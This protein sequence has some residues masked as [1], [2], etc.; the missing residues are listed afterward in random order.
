MPFFDPISVPPNQ[1][2]NTSPRRWL[3]WFAIPLATGFLWLAESGRRD[4]GLNDDGK[5]L[6]IW[7]GMLAG[8]ACIL[9]SSPRQRGLKWVLL[10]LYPIV[11]VPIFTAIDFMF[12]GIGRLF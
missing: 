7:F 9:S 10:A 11:M 4:G 3:P 2:Q 1:R 8:L 5:A 6:F 12:N